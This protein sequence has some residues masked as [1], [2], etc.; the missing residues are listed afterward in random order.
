MKKQFNFTIN[1]IFFISIAVLFFSICFTKIH[2]FDFFWHL[3]AGEEILKNKA[4][5]YQDI[6]SYTKEGIQWF[7]FH[8]IFQC[9]IALANKFFG[10]FGVTV[11]KVFLFALIFLIISLKKNFNIFNSFALFIAILCLSSRCMERPEIFSYLFIV[12]MIILL[13]KPYTF[14]NAIF[15][16]LIQILMTNS[17]SI[18]LT[19]PI[20]IF[21]RLVSSLID[22]KN[23]KEYL[24]LLIMAIL[25]CA[26]SPFGFKGLLFPLLDVLPKVLQGSN[27]YK[28]TIGEFTSFN[29]LSEENL[30]RI[31]YFVLA[32]FTF[33]N[34]SSRRKFFELF[35][36][37][38]F[39][40]LALK[41]VRNFNLF[42]FASLGFILNNPDFENLDKKINSSI[43][44]IFVV[45]LI[46]ISVFYSWLFSSN[47][48]YYRYNS[49]PRFGGGFNESVF[50][51]DLPVF[52]NNLKGNIKI[53]NSMS[54]GGYLIYYV[55]K[56]KVFFDGRLDV[57][58]DEHYVKYLKMIS[59]RSYFFRE[60][61]KYGINVVIL[62]H[63]INEGNKLMSL[64]KENGWDIG[65]IDF[66]AVVFIKQGIVSGYNPIN[67]NNIDGITKRLEE[68]I[69]G[70]DEPEKKLQ[71][72]ILRLALNNLFL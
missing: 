35:I 45:I 36:M 44:K 41:A 9:S 15:I 5:L 58:G 59:D 64:A 60:S 49:L 43:K 8:I 30:F 62:N 32:G 57:Y 17:H 16:I 70:F 61:L 37:L 31:F 40:I 67:K 68:S 39:A 42:L 72:N 2:N 66:H 69:N 22:K 29:V 11:F 56:Y 14:L 28:Q 6:F 3:K 27:V 24:M 1:H 48:I 33:I 38:S 63:S 46:F 4:F 51:K 34:F 19:G 53:F 26:I 23:S 20:I 47:K 25:A 65:Y 7:N 10:L 13:E 18:F 50:S 54:L 55:P 21:I 71:L 52:L 12:L